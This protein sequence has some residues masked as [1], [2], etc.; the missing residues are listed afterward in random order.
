MAEELGFDEPLGM[1][2]QFT[3]TNFFRAR[4]LL[5]WMARATSSLPVPLSPVTR[6]LDS[7][8]AAWRM[9]RNISRISGL[10]PMML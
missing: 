6:T 10:L 5:E 4:T 7:L 9:M 1:A 2:P 8:E 3:V